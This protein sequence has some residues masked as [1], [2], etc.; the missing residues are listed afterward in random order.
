MKNAEYWIALQNAV[1]YASVKTQRILEAFDDI[2][3]FFRLGE[4]AWR[5]LHLFTPAELKRLKETDLK[6]SRQI[7]SLCRE[8]N[9][10]ILTPEDAEYPEHLLR[11]KDPPAV[12]YVSGNLPDM[13]D[14]A[15]VAMVGTRKSSRSGEA[16][17]YTLGYRLGGAGAVI[18]SGGAVGIDTQSSRGALDAGGRTVIVLGCGLRYP[19]LL[20]NKALRDKAAKSGAVISEFQPECQPSRYSFPIRNRLMSALANCV[21]VVQAPAKSGALITASHALEQG[22]DVFAIPGDIA[23]IDFAGC[24]KILQDGARPVYTPQDVLSEYSAVFPHKLNLENTD[25][26]IG[27]DPVFLEHYQQERAQTQKPGGSRSAPVQKPR[28][29]ELRP[30]PLPENADA[31][32]RKIYSLFTKDP[33]T[34]DIL[35]QSSGLAPDDVL[36]AVTNLQIDGCIDELPGGRFVLKWI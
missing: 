8:R 26:P 23:S 22:K 12:L 10:G 6:K 4:S 7:L 34:M 33:V 15:G 16:A 9:I 32:M 35:I 5:D 1:G 30:V 28:E 18:I 27:E 20:K 11:I 2:A 3:A 24:N 29:P 13:D 21:I 17:A 25:I 19:Y 36:V 14:E 31:A